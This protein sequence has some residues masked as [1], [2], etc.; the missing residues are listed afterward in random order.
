M[1]EVVKDYSEALDSVNLIQ[2]QLAVFARAVVGAASGG[3]SKFEYFTLG[4][5][6]VALANAIIALVESD[7]AVRQDILYVLEHGVWTLEA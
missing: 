1:V 7:A 4:L 6:G 2:K 5:K 3:I